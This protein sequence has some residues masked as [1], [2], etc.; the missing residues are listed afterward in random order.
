MLCLPAPS[1]LQSSH[2]SM[3]PHDGIRHHTTPLPHLLLSAQLA[4]C[5]ASLLEWLC[6]TTENQD[7]HIHTCQ[8]K[9]FPGSLAK[10]SKFI[11]ATSFMSVSTLSTRS[12]VLAPVMHSP[13]SKRSLVS[14]NP[15][16]SCSSWE[17]HWSWEKKSVPALELALNSG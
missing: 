3:F 1:I 6:V 10:I 4:T 17:I 12:N 16:F 11:T 5:S 2:T 7:P 8:K 15:Y 9:T 14:C 13:F